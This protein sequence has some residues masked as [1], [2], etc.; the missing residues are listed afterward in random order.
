MYIWSKKKKGGKDGCCGVIDMVETG[1]SGE[2]A[3]LLRKRK[4]TQERE[5]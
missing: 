1:R 4:Q 5:R 3:E 2:R